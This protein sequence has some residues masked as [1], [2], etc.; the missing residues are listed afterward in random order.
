MTERVDIVAFSVASTSASKI[1]LQSLEAKH[2]GV[3]RNINDGAQ[4][5][6]WCFMQFSLYLVVVTNSRSKSWC[7][8]RTIIQTRHNNFEANSVLLALKYSRG[9]RWFS[10][11]V[12]NKLPEHF[13][14]SFSVRKYYSH[15]DRKIDSTYDKS[16]GSR[17][18]HFS[19]RMCFHISHYILK[20]KKKSNN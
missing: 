2:K 19:L 3:S 17:K 10:L 4:M 14:D 11:K 16:L 13:E 1:A 9:I 15:R 6:T 12:F 5:I 20:E 18:R 7:S 8:T